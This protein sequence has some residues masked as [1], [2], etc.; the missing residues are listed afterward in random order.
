MPVQWNRCPCKAHP[1]IRGSPFFL[2][3]MLA[4]EMLMDWVGHTVLPEQSTDQKEAGKLGSSKLS[5]WLRKTSQGDAG[6]ASVGCW[7]VIRMW[8]A[9]TEMSAI[10]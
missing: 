9:T 10:F 3:A 8:G 7:E 5:S 2:A 4:R 6:Q 1:A